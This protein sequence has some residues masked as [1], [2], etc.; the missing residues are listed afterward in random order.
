MPVS[1][2]FYGSLDDTDCQNLD[3][4]PEEHVTSF[5]ITYNSNQVTQVHFETSNG[6]QLSSGKSSGREDEQVQTFTYDGNSTQLIGL[7]ST[8]NT[9]IRSLGPLSIDLEMA[10]A[11]PFDSTIKFGHITL[12]G[13]LIGGASILFIFASL[14]GTAYYAYVLRLRATKQPFPWEN[15]NFKKMANSLGFKKRNLVEEY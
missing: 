10:S 14:I 8:T 7:W 15:L 4:T 11:R 2:H 5:D 3:L 13:Y 6:E 1:L 9:T 12:K